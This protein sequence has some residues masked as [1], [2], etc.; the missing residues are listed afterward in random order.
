MDNCFILIAGRLAKMHSVR[1]NVNGVVPQPCLFPM[2]FKYLHLIP[3]SFPDPVKDERYK[4][5]IKPKNV[6]EAEINSLKEELVKLESPVVFSHN[7]LL[8]KNVIY[9]KE[10]EEVTFIDY[11]Y[12]DYNYQAFDI[13]NHFCEF[14]GLEHSPR[15]GMSFL[16]QHHIGG[17]LIIANNFDVQFPL[18]RGRH[19]SFADAKLYQEF[20]FAKSTLWPN[21]SVSRFYTT[22]VEKFDPKLYPDKDFQMRWLKEYLEA[23]YLENDKSLEDV[24]EEIVE[25]FYIQVNKFALAAHL[26]WGTWGLI[27]S[28]HSTLDFD[29]LGY[30][31]DRLDEYFARKDEF[32]SLESSQTCPD[33]SS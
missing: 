1:S 5:L 3:D 9:N 6:L 22:G 29:F 10:K 11:E 33:K 23:W 2:L 15:A 28:A 18:C 8:L 26:L 17:I 31:K 30:A 16:V 24:T 4:S 27:Q 21:G 7:D 13:G 14:A 12:A 32:L 25:D 19:L 20:N